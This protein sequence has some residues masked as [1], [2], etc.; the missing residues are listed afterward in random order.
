MTPEASF[1]LPRPG[2]EVLIAPIEID[3]ISH[4]VVDA[5]QN[6]LAALIPY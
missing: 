2:S 4:V 3:V 6:Y 1:R 5:H